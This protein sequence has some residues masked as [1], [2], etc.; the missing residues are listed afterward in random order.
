MPLA[1][2]V[3]RTTRLMAAP[4]GQAVESSRGRSSARRRW[5]T[6]MPAPKPT[7]STRS[8]ACRRP[9]SAA[10]ARAS[11]IDAALVLPWRS[12]VTTAR[13]MRMPEP[14]ARRVDDA[15][16]GLVGD[17]QGEVVDGDAGPL[18]G[19]QRR[20][21]HRAHGPAEHLL[22][23]HL[24]EAADVGGEQVAGRPV[25]VEVE[26]EQVA[27]A[28]GGLEH[29]RAGAV[30]EEDG[31]AA[32]V[33]VDDAAHGLG[34]DEQHPVEPGREEAVRRR[35]GR[36]RSRSRRRS[37]RR[38]RRGCRARPARSRPWPAWPGRGWWWPRSTRSTSAASTPAE[39]RAGRAGLG[40]QARRW[41]RRCAARGCRCAR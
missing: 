26:A 30:G 2:P 25:G 27:R 19:P 41:C 9:A 8:P 37:G 20:V 14:L 13:S 36:R 35:P 1:P 22:A 29:D 10:S 18:E 5:P 7:S 4:V 39:R 28:V 15:D 40:G 24:D 31:R 34:A 11:G 12:T 16:V 38:R 6:L 33:P 17:D 21:D 23:V 3:T 32:V